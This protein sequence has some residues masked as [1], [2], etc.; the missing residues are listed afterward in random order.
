MLESIW[1]A[2]LYAIRCPLAQRLALAQAVLRTAACFETRMQ[3]THVSEL[4]YAYFNA[5]QVR[6]WEI[7]LRDVRSLY[8]R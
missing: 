5:V 8:I 1:P 3:Q 6:P 4:A 7:N 2:T